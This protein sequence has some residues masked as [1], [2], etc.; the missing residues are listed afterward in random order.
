MASFL[1]KIAEPV[2]V[3]LWSFGLHGSHSNSLLAKRPYEK[4]SKTR[5]V[6]VITEEFIED[7]FGDLGFDKAKKAVESG[8]FNRY[9]D[10][11]KNGSELL[12]G[13]Y[14]GVKFRVLLLDAEALE[15]LTLM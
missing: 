5:D 7:K 6:I 1:V 4:Q 11:S 10:S 9:F 12:I 13:R 3:D 8:D 2:M 14:A 15:W